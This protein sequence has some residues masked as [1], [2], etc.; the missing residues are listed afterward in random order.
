[1]TEIS[2]AE[3][4]EIQWASSDQGRV[5][6]RAAHARAVAI[7]AKVD[8]AEAGAI[9][10]AACLAAGWN[11]DGARLEPFRDVESFIK[12]LDANGVSTSVPFGSRGIDAARLMAGITTL[13][14]VAARMAAQR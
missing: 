3:V 11:A 13:V 14:D 8:M 6:V 5:A 2:D 12:W 1:M 7:G 9:V 4:A 10:Y